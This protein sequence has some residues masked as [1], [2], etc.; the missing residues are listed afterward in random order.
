MYPTNEFLL[1][2][3]KR[4]RALLLELRPILLKAHGAIEHNLKDDASVVTEMDLMVEQRLQIL[5]KEID[6]SIG[7]A[8]EETGANYDQKTF[9]L[10]DPIDGTEAFIRGLPFSTNMI[11]LI[12]NNMPIMAVIYN[13]FLD[14]Y[15]LAIKGK[16]ATCN[17]HPI[18]VSD[19]TLKRAQVVT[20]SGFARAGFVGVNDRLRGM[21]ANTMQL[22]ASGFEHAAVARGAFDARIG[23]NARGK[24]WDFAPG[25]L[26]V[27]E[28]GGRVENLGSTTYTY[29]NTNFVAANPVIFDDLK[30]FVEEA[31]KTTVA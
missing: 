14:E 1:T 29:R 26:L 21:V 23:F 31:T 6:P 25:T 28:A 22:C 18:H 30:R 7:F 19:R 20:G 5:C 13:F 24:A 3:E 10:V 15:Y 17:G 2:A 16:G 8:G 11:T 4:L 12:D 9:W 27:Q